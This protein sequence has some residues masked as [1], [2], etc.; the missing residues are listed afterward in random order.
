VGSEEKDQIWIP[1]IVFD[2]GIKES[3]IKN[4]EFAILKIIQNGTGSYSMNNELQENVEYN[5]TANKLS[6]FRNYK[7]L[8]ICEF[9]QYN[10]PFDYQTCPITVIFITFFCIVGTII[11]QKKNFNYLN[12]TLKEIIIFS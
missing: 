4:D 1:N 8:L 10:Y 5:G 3:H 12:A 9:E 7:M 11:F 6:F 2:N